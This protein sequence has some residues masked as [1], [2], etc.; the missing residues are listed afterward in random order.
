MRST[1]RVRAGAQIDYHAIRV[2][3]TAHK[4]APSRE[5]SVMRSTI[6][7]LP[8]RPFFTRLTF[9]LHWRTVSSCHFWAAAGVP[10]STTIRVASA[11]LPPTVSA[12]ILAVTLPGT[13]TTGFFELLE[14][15]AAI[16]LPTH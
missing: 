3:T 5:K 16:T 14:L 1:V 2:M 13:R 10:L 9:T 6:K 15:D 4:R 7:L 8:G 11:R 12:A